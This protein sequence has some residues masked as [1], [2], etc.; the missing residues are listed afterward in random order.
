MPVFY[1]GGEGLKVE[2]PSMP[3]YFRYSL[4]LLIPEIEEAWSLGIKC[5]NTYIKCPQELKDNTG[6]EAW[7][8]EG[9]MQR[10]IPRFIRPCR[11]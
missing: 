8:T 4:D 2:I 3:G 11:I 5:V 9:L 7:N 6:K 1:C 10:S